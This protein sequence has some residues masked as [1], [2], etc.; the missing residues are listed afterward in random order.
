MTP[1]LV[2]VEWT[3]AGQVITYRSERDNRWCREGWAI[4][5][6]SGYFLDTYWQSTG[7]AHRVTADELATAEHQFWV[8]D[9][10]E[11][12]RYGRGTPDEW[13]KYAPADRQ[14][15]P[16]QHGLQARF[17]VRIGAEHDLPTQVE[18]AIEALRRAEDE[19][20]SAQRR[21]EYAQERVDELRDRL[22]R[23]AATGADQ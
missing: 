22:S 15:V 6:E 21:M 7:D 16:S 13:A 8:D 23:P 17:F 2:P 3:A 1:E 4:S 19:A 10:R 14:R 11:L 12:D 9:Y 20:E 18:N 5:S